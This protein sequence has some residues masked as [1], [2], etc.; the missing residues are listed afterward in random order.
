MND[1]LH[2]NGYIII[3]D[4]LGY[5]QKE[6]ALSSIIQV[7]G[8]K[9]KIDYNIFNEFI[10][11]DFIPKINET[12][13]W[14]S[15]YLKYRFSNFQNAKDAA[16]FHGD[17]YNFADEDLMPIYTGLIYFDKSILEIIPGS[18]IK[19]NLSTNE[20]YAMKKQIKPNAGDMIVFHANI[21]HRGIF[22]E[23]SE[24]RRLLQVFDIFPNK[25]IYMS[26]YPKFLSVI[27]GQKFIT[28]H[29]SFISEAIS[30]N[31]FLDT[32]MTYLSYLMVNNGVQYKIIMSDITDEQKKGRYVGY[33]PG[34]IDTV[35][36]GQLQDWNIN[37]TVIEHNTI[38]PNTT[39]QKITLALVL[40]LLASRCNLNSY[41]KYIKNN[42]K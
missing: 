7:G 26:Y 14:S 10:N 34:L 35:K 15:I 12:L 22:Y 21:H 33:V 42:K 38:I 36:P 6:R 25:Y 23:T 1:E 41:N 4:P 13:G 30:K 8:G 2:K 3:K 28:T 19:N 37:M 17:V 5:S 16:Q 27:T 39:S 29:V 20:L 31:K 9:T 24:N 11:N 40:I 32:I 18:H